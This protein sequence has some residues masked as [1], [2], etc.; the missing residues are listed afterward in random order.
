MLRASTPDRTKEALRRFR[1]SMASYQS[2]LPH[3]IVLKRPYCVFEHPLS[4]S[5]LGTS[6]LNNDLDLTTFW[7]IV[8]ASYQCSGASRQN[9]NLE[10]YDSLLVHYVMT[11]Y[12]CSGPQGGITIWMPY[13]SLLI[14]VTALYQ[15]S[16][17]NTE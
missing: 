7:S 11:S 5:M 3:R 2:G 1:A 15:C 9:N 17:L 12:Q 16:D 8:W 14:H 4:V 10:A 13:D 6:I